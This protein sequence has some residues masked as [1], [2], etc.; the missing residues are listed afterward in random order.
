MEKGCWG[1]KIYDKEGGGEKKGQ[2][3]WKKLGEETAVSLVYIYNTA[4]NED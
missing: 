1:P 2:K 4:Y 3:N